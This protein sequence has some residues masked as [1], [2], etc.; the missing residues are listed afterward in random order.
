MSSPKIITLQPIPPVGNERV[1]P[2]SNPIPYPQYLYLPISAF[3][4]NLTALN[5]EISKVG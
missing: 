1:S 5:K 2:L 4:V 3:S